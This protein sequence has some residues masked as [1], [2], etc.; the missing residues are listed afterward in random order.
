MG[1]R[2]SRVLVMKR[3]GKR[4]AS[5]GIRLT[6]RPSSPNR[7]TLFVKT[8]A[9]SFLDNDVTSL[10]QLIAYN[11]LFAIA[12]LLI[13]L[14]AF[15]GLIVQQV[16]AD[17]TNPV[18]PLL[19]WLDDNL[20]S[21]AAEFLKEPVETALATS[22]GFL[23]SIGGLLTL[24]SAKGAIV[25]ITRGLN[26]TYGIDDSRSFLRK[27][28]ISIMLT[29]GLAVAI[30]V[31]GAVQLLGSD[32][33]GDIAGAIGLGSVWETA[34]SWLR[35][36]ITVVLVTLIIVLLHRY[37]PDFNAPLRWYLPGALFTIAGM[38]V[39]VIG[40]RIYFSVSGGFSA[41]YGI[42]GSVLAFIFFLYVSGIVILT[43]GI[44]NA[45]LFA[46]YPRAR[47]ALADFREA[48][49]LGQHRKQA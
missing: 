1:L 5:K 44:V 16:N 26:A 29:I 8:A 22:P 27:H 3:R 48:K 46:I 24:W 19:D 10:A 7:Q 9:R 39:A 6:S 32:L 41:A 49:I 15:C 35:W 33:G 28:L 30:L 11:L 25:A 43:G 34:M 2:A 12:P 45:T 14:T 20:P 42:F 31:S 47:T 37:A 38:L 36:P 21:D 18:R 23:L 17:A 40:L 13:F 4:A